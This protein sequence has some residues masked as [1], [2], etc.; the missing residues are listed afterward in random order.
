MNLQNEVHLAADIQPP[1]AATPSGD[2]QHVLLTG[3]TGYLGAH[4]VGDLLQR[5]DAAVHCL[6]RAESSAHADQR[7]LAN[8]Q[9]YGI[10]FA[11]FR[12]RLIA[13][14]GNISQDNL[15]LPRAKL[16]RLAEQIDAAYHAGASNGPWPAMGAGCAEATA[17]A[18]GLQRACAN[19]RPNAAY[20]SAYIGPV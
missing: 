10:D 20:R 17:R 19:W 9:R 13:I 12:Q 1:A 16:D 18:N 3:G 5:T 11:E 15:G 4:L 14:P 8:M 2:Q 7:L 6:I